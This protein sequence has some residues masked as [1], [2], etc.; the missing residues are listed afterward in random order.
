MARVDAACAPDARVVVPQPVDM[1][2]FGADAA[3]V[4]PDAAEDRV[5][6]GG[7]FFRKRRNEI[8]A[9]ERCSAAMADLAH[10]PPA[11]F[12]IGGD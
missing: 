3:E 4:V 8:G 11:K 1:G 9:A 6:L 12:A 7:G 5:D 2:E 10:Q